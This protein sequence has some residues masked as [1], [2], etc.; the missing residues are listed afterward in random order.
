M[1]AHHRILFI[2]V[3]TRCLA[4]LIFLAFFPATTARADTLRIATWH[5]DL[6]RKGPGLLLRDI[7]AEKDPDIAA[8]LA[9]ITRLNADFLLLSDFDYDLDLQTLTALRDRLARD[10]PSYPHLFALRPNTGIGTGLDLDGDGRLGGPGDAQGFGYFNGQGGL[11]ILSRL[12]INEGAVT[13]LSGLLWRD[14][15]DSRMA[16]GDPGADI[17]RLS[18]SGH[19]D[20]PVMLSQVKSLNILV[21]HAT[22]P[23]FDGPEDRNG[24][25]NADELMLWQKYL[26]G[27]LPQP[28]PTQNYILLGNANLDPRRG[29]GLTTVMQAFL[30]DPR[31]QD[32]APDTDT[33]LWPE[34]GPMRVSYALPSAD[35]TV[36]AAGQGDPVGAHRPVWVDITVPP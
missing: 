6:S 16:P 21:F 32:P 8:I 10:G 12:P 11:A 14:L 20:V 24:R 7:L 17:Q 36:L 29:D 34:T 27:A 1:R 28:P 9:G 31:F 22:P 2:G 30:R 3:L 13:D 25:R 15:P 19:W 33:A 26:N 23:V 35:L 5:A 18:T 4:A